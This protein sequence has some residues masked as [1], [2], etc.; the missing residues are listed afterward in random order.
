M[1]THS[2]H[3]AHDDDTPTEEIPMQTRAQSPK[4]LVPVDVNGCATEVVE[5]AIWLA[6]MMHAE[7]L[8]LAAFD[9]PLGAPA[10]AHIHIDG[11]DVT[12]DHFLEDELRAALAPLVRSVGRAGVPLRVDIRH[13]APVRAILSACEEFTPDLVVMGTHGRTGISRVVF[14]SVA[15]SVLHQAPCPVL[16]VPAGRGRREVLSDAM[17]Q[18]QAEANG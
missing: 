13:G 2:H 6:Q 3:T 11:R 15:E 14:G 1:S 8:L 5:R 12:I 16:I 18:V 9:E 17:K 10:E 4:L 7:I